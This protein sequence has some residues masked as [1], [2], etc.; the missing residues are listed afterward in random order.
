MNTNQSLESIHPEGEAKKSLK[1]APSKQSSSITCD[2][3]QGIVHLEWDPQAPVT[4]L[5]Q[6]PF[7]IDFLKTTKIYDKWI[8]ECPLNFKTQKPS[9][10]GVRNI[11]GTFFLSCLSG[12]K[13]YAHIT[14]MRNDEVNP[15]LLGMDKIVSEDTAR[16]AFQFYN[17][18]VEPGNEEWQRRY[19]QWKKQCSQWQQKHLAKCYES[20]M[21]EPWILDLDTTVKLLYGHQEG[22]EIGYNPK[23]PGRPSH[24][25]H[26]YDGRSS[27]YFRL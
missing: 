15:P 8:E 5:G 1:P 2:T 10:S 14:A 24:Y 12:Q 7:F 27:N 11:L 25:S 13:R 17:E 4:P 9:S 20:L 21:C 26:L 6:L 18:E 23:K 22:A 19:E 16:R 3:F